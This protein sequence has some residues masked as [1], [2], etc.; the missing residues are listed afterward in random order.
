MP[1]SDHLKAIPR[2]QSRFL[3]RESGSSGAL[4]PCLH[5]V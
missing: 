4:R 2:R 1:E 3:G 5:R